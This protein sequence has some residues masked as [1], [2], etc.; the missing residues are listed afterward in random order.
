MNQVMFWCAGSRSAYLDPTH[1]GNRHVQRQG[2]GEGEDILEVIGDW[3]AAPVLLG[4]QTSPEGQEDIRI[5]DGRKEY[6]DLCGAYSML[7]SLSF[8]DAYVDR[9]GLR[10]L[11][12]RCRIISFLFVSFIARS[13]SVERNQ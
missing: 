1:P 5:P 4:I 8:V 11:E 10:V 12:V 6:G 3:S 2:R 9:R 13:F 7:E